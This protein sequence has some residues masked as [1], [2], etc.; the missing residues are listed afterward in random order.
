MDTLP[1]IS[2]IV[3]SLNQGRYLAEALESIFRQGYP[4]LQVVLMDGGSTD[5]TVEIVRAYESRLTYWQSGSD[6]GQAAAINEGARHCSGDL[7]GWLNSDD[8]YLRDSLWTVARAHAA[9]PKCGLYIG[10]GFRHRQEDGTLIPFS[11][12][13]VALNRDA[14][15]KG[16]DYVLQPSTFFSTDAWETV[17]G[18]DPSL[19]FCLDWDL[20]MRVAQKYPAVLINEFLSVSREHRST[21]TSTGHMERVFEI[22]RMVKQRTGREASLGTLYYWT[23]ALLHLTDGSI[24]AQVRAPLGSVQTSVRH[25]FGRAFGNSDGFPEKTDFDDTIYLP[26]A[27]V[28]GPT[29]SAAGTESLP[30]ISVVVPSLDQAAFLGQALDSIVNQ[31]YP[32]TEIIVCDGGSTDGSVGLRQQ[33]QHRLAYWVSEP[34]RGP[35]HAINKGFARATGEIFGWLNSDDMLA[36]G[37]LAAVGRAFAEDPDL[38]MVYANAL[39]VDED[40][41]LHLADHGGYRT[42][43]Y[44]GEMPSREST[45]RYWS[46]VHAVPQ[47][48]VFFR[49]RL[50]DSC[51]PL[52]ERYHFI[53]DFELFFRFSE[54]ARIKKLERTQAF[55]RIHRAAKSSDWRKFLIELYRFSRPSWPGLLDRDF[56]PYWR[57]FLGSYARR[58]FGGKPRT[59]GQWAILASA[60]ISSLTRAGNPEALMA[61]SPPAPLGP[62][63][64]RGH[65]FMPKRQ[66]YAID[67]HPRYRSFFCSLT[68]PKHPGHSGGE[69]RD[70]HLLRELLRISTVEFFSVH[71]LPSDERVDLF[72]AFLDAVHAPD[73]VSTSRQAF[74]PRLV[75]AAQRR[76]WPV[77]GARYHTE[78]KEQLAVIEHCRIGLEQALQQH[79]PDFLFVSPQVNPIALTLDTS[80]LRTRLVMA[81][82]DVEA[83]RIDSFAQA[84]RGLQRVALRLERDRA[85]RFEA[86]NLRAFDGIIAVS[87]RDKD[88]F[89]GRYGFSPDR[90]LVIAN[91]VDPHYFAFAGRRETRSPQV[92]FVGTLDYL[93]NRRAAWRLVDDI[94]PRVRRRCPQATVWVVGQNPE[95]ALQA[96]ADGSLTVVTGAVDDVRPYL[97][98]ATVA[99]IPLTAG[100]GTKYKVLEALSAGVPTVCTSSALTGLELKDAEHLIVRDTDEELAGA[101]VDLI[102]HPELGERLARQGRAQVERLYTWDTNLPVLDDWLRLL[103]T[104]PRRGGG[105]A[106]AR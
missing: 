20:I 13:H 14:L 64:S 44:Y 98:Q 72:E 69:I 17:G 30:S 32:R 49:R 11:K 25:L 31:G 63:A 39:Y 93:A 8:Y 6:G 40:T 42:G 101:I 89:V 48:T 9:S 80:A 85:R 73:A 100:A 29:E 70:F 92:V 3:P 10:N 75:G 36:A 15:V 26:L 91:S 77:L 22:H 87:E 79:P 82:Y 102:E 16:L 76:R 43:L 56:Y 62:S 45:P 23:E 28:D 94:M 12:R 86:E 78:S 71:T 61:P 105:P 47:P 51:G 19:R 103:D 50:L 66:S 99:C 68:F 88:T 35:A 57:D 27:T 106:I 5:N 104:L 58:H 97:A 33:Y 2:V 4:R 7:L 41:R 37:A 34:D 95:P 60:A 83:E 38:D 24:P 53:F 54:R 46:Y 59:R 18:L 84:S 81:S 52:D 90:V 65:A 96:R 1:A 55:Y 67:R 74:F 21:K